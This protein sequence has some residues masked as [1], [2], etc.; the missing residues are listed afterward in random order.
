MGVDLGR[1]RVVTRCV[2]NSPSLR[3][4]FQVTVEFFIASSIAGCNFVGRMVAVA[5]QKEFEVQVPDLL[6]SVRTQQN[7]QHRTDLQQC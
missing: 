3:N 7:T 2:E 4:I 6:G 1:A 5:V